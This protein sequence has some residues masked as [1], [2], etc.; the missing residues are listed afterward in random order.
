MRRRDL[1]AAAPAAL[2]AACSQ[3]PRPARTATDA[4]IPSWLDAGPMIGHARTDGFVVWFRLARPTQ[5]TATARFDGREI[6][7]ASVVDL[8]E[9]CVRVEF[10]G[11]PSATT[12]EVRIVPTDVTGDAAVLVATTAPAASTI[13]RVRLAFGSCAKDVEF[14]AVPAFSAMAEVK[15]DFALFLGDNSYFVRSASDR[16]FSTDEGPGEWESEPLMLARHLATRR[17]PELQA[18][19]RSTPCYAIWDDHDYGPNN[20]DRT[21]ALRSESL[22]CFQRVWA[23][24]SYG[25]TT[26]QG[27]FSSFRRGPVEVF[28]TDGR[29]HRLSPRRAKELGTKPVIWGAEQ[30][31]WL[32]DGLRS[33]DA[34]VKIIACGTQFMNQG[35]P[36]DGHWH[37]ARDE[38]FALLERIDSDRVG[39]VVF[40]S[41][42]RHYSELMQLARTGK[43]SL[44]EFTSSPLQQGRSLGPRDD[45]QPTRRF[46]MDGN[47][48][49]MV[50]IDV[51]GPRD[52]EITFE[53]RTETGE[54]AVVAG[55]PMRLTLDLREL[56]WA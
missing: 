49:G 48:F 12:T 28:L 34:P 4:M 41:G 18:L 23:N 29:F 44:V 42:D 55:E 15:P 19:L 39:G 3:S 54:R 51:R 10:A 21:F 37:E 20:S 43:P 11:I 25:T 16:L 6:P 50:T 47:S 13:G 46:A 1:L 56:S 45:G 30:F 38:F 7:P 27:V 24:P 32:A 2:L 35:E 8:G 22:R 26:V 52:G 14:G 31:A 36:D 33:S 40:L 17:R 9:G 53:C 5:W